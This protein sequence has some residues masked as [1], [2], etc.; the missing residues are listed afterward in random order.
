VITRERM[1]G[2]IKGETKNL[3]LRWIYIII[4]VLVFKSDS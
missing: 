2:A 3:W 1:A 4:L